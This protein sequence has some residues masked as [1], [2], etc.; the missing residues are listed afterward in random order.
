LI[1]IR[2]LH[3]ALTQMGKFHVKGCETT[4]KGFKKTTPYSDYLVI[5]A[6]VRT[7]FC[8]DFERKVPTPALTIP[9]P[10]NAPIRAILRPLRGQI[11][12]K[13]SRVENTKADLQVPLWQ[14]H[15]PALKLNILLGLLEGYWVPS[16]W[17]LFAAS[18]VSPVFQD[19]IRQ[20][21]G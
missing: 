20:L 10:L 9:P 4:L 8:P 17:V 18:V 12:E 5:F 3:V 13:I 6:K 19:E 7:I 21:L 16:P 14:R 2:Y 1:F 15:S 11:R